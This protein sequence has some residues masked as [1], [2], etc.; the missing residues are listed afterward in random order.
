MIHSHKRSLKKQ[1][2]ASIIEYALIVAAVV[3]IGVYALVQT[4]NQA[5]LAVRSSK[6]WTIRRVS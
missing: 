3:A 6:N 4:E 5:R 2:G 1:R